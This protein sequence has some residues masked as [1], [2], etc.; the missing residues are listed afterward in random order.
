M[1][2]T[3]QYQRVRNGSMADEDLLPEVSREYLKCDLEILIFSKPSFCD[4]IYF[5]FWGK[6]E[7][8]FRM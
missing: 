1:L 6:E 8:E 5:I 2:S 3:K 4:L 7:I